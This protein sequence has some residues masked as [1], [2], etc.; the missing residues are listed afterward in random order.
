M[1][2]ANAT[3]ISP[4]GA[5]AYA[6][7]RNS[8]SL[9]VSTAG[10]GARS[11]ST[12]AS[13]TQRSEVAPTCRTRRS[14]GQDVVVSPDG[15]SVYVAGDNAHAISTFGGSGRALAFAGCHAN[16]VSEGCADLP[17]APLTNPGG[18]AVSPDGT[19]VYVISPGSDSISE[20]AR[21]TPPEPALT[22]DLAAKRKQRVEKLAATATC[23]IRA[24]SRCG[25]RERPPRSSR[26]SSRATI[27]APARRRRSS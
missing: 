17:G 23:W 7:G 12:A 25:R 13:P 21:E 20:F 4:D 5:S 15:T 9:A 24:R 6:V 11:R 19:S 3:V 10:Q 18:L 16:D 22:L 2:Q 14:T 26:R 8:D 27:S 1:S